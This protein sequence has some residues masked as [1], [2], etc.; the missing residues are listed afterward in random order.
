MAI[1]KKILFLSLFCTL[2]FSCRKEQSAA[3]GL[4]IIGSW[5]LTEL[6]QAETRAVTIG[7]ESIDIY[8]HFIADNSF[9]LYQKV[10]AGKFRYFSGT[11]TLID[12]KL[13]GMYHDKTAWGTEYDVVLNCKST[14]LRLTSGGEEYVYSKEEIPN[15]VLSGIK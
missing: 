7:Q 15:E 1:M 8:I 13:S 6:S 11:W 9:H 4:N 3:E 14:E 2:L 12:N 5:H 10:G